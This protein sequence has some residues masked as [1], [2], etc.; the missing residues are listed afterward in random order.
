MPTEDGFIAQIYVG[1]Q[2]MGITKYYRMVRYDRSYN[3]VVREKVSFKAGKKKGKFI[4]AVQHGGNLLYFW[5]VK[6]GVLTN[7]YAQKVNQKTLIATNKKVKI[8]SVSEYGDDF[9]VYSQDRK[10]LV[11]INAMQGKDKAS[12]INT[13]SFLGEDLAVK[14]KYKV[15]TKA[16]KNDDINYLNFLPEENGN[17]HILSKIIHWDKGGKLKHSLTSYT[18]AT[19]ITK[20]S[21]IEFNNR[22]INYV[23]MQFFNNDT[24]VLAGFYAG[25]NRKVINFTRTTDGFFSA[26]YIIPEDK[27]SFTEDAKISQS[28]QNSSYADTKGS[29]EPMYEYT[30]YRRLELAVNENKE[31][32]LIAEQIYDRPETTSESYNDIIIIGF[33]T[34]GKHNYI[35]KIVKRQPTSRWYE[36]L[37]SFSYNFIDNKLNIYYSDSE[38]NILYKQG[39]KVDRLS[40]KNSILGKKNICLTRATIEKDGKVSQTHLLSKENIK[41][42]LMVRRIVFLNPKE[43][44]FTGIY[45]KTA[46]SGKI[47]MK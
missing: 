2:T 23:Q 46:W 21:D 7:I 14:Y 22:A 19:R 18:N 36:C 47:K 38:Q 26:K 9:F 34:K 32:F 15:K 5:R 11:Y 39:K 16:Q 20:Q 12:M 44:I 42:P 3:E 17:I 41:E 37:S 31:Y 29:I 4:A 43:F 24:I 30:S 25:A 10:H 1:K 28:F 27:F 40:C 8:A 33:N 35:T 45:N 13:V 6:S